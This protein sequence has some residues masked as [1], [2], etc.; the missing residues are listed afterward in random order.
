M[1]KTFPTASSA[2]RIGSSE[3]YQFEVISTANQERLYGF[4][5]GFISLEEEGASYAISDE[6]DGKL[7]YTNG[8]YIIFS[9]PDSIALT[10]QGA[11][12]LMLST[13]AQEQT[14]S[15]L[16]LTDTTVYLRLARPENGDPWGLEFTLKFYTQINQ[17]VHRNSA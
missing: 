14:A 9:E 8:G 3:P 1:K 7:P 17:I 4:S 16:I 12:L 5:E 10:I 2:I 13:A 15:S 6:F 11:N